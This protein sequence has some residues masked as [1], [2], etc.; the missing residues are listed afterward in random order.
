M[1]VTIAYLLI[2]FIVGVVMGQFLTLGLRRGH[3]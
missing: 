3:K 2:G 1:T